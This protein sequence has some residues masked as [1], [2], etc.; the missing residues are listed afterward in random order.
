MFLSPV[1]RLLQLSTVRQTAVLLVLFCAISLLA[2]GG[3][4]WSISREMLQAVDG[5]LTARME[6]V[7]A[8]VEATG[9]LPRM[10]D[11]RS[12]RWAETGWADGFVALDLAE[13]EGPDYRYLVRTTT[14]GRIAVGENFERQE[15][16]QDILRGGM[17]LAF[18]ATLLLTLIAGVVLALR[19]QR[20]LRAINEGLVRVGRGALDTRIMLKGEDDLSLLAGRINTTVERLEQTMEQMRVQSSAIAHDLR[21]PLARLRAQIETNLEALADRNIPVAPDALEADLEQIDQITEIFDA[22]LRLARIESGAGKERFQLVSLSDVVR[23]AAET[24]EPVVADAGQ[25]LEAE[26]EGSARI[27][28]DESLLLQLVANLIQNALRYGP[29]GQTIRLNCAGAE[30]SV[31]DQGPGIPVADQERVLQP[32]YQATSTRQEEGSGLGLSLVRAIAELHD[33]ELAFSEGPGLT[34]CVRFP[35]GK[36]A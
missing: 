19:G 25:R 4:Y 27:S 35:H 28:G 23:H 15:E 17:Q 11:P 3:T 31:S 14:L 34:V 1:R 10:E 33:A 36:P 18:L 13:G 30:L 22:L 16:L 8:R 6:E 7:A 29:E 2:W 32:F 21:T 26:L 9:T 20:R 12:V 24:F 5:R